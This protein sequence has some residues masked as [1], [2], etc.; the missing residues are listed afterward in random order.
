MTA[1]TVLYYGATNLLKAIE[2]VPFAAN[3]YP[4]TVAE[5]SL[6]SEMMDK[7][8]SVEQRDELVDCLAF[9][10]NVGE[11]IS[12]SSMV[13][14]N[15]FEFED[16]GGKAFEVSAFFFFHDLNV[17]LY[18]LAVY[19]GDYEVQP[20]EREVETMNKLAAELVEHSRNCAIRAQITRAG[21]SA[22]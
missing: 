21:N 15:V 3:E 17:P 6:A 14:R 22:Q 18:I 11:A 19:I 20:N 7:F 1:T 8:L 13:R 16:S 5:V 9:Q 4:I 10:P 12:A 2:N